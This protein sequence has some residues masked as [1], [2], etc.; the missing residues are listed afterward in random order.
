MKAKRENKEVVIEEDEGLNSDEY[1][2]R[3]RS[4]NSCSSDDLD[5]ELNLSDCEDKA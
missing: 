4:M 2:A 5:G 1:E 3:N